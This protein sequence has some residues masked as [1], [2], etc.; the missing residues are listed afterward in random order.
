MKKL[1]TLPV[2]GVVVAMLGASVF[3]AS[4]TPGAIKAVDASGKD[5]G[6]KIVI[7]R[8]TS[9]QG[10]KGK[11]LAD[12]GLEAG[13]K[14]FKDSE[15]TVVEELDIS[16]NTAAGWTLADIEFPIA[17]TIDPGTSGDAIVGAHYTG[18]WGELVS[19]SS[20]EI[21]LKAESTLSPFLIAKA[22]AS[23]SAQTGEYAGAYIVMV[24]VAL[25]AAG[26]VFAVRAKKATR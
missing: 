25:V 11:T 22:S 24:A 19:G 23:S 7:T 18:K 26:A 2:I 10:V 12:I 3:A 16:V 13:N 17:V 9:E 6:D 1:M 14:D 15:F 21:T 20:S 5:L 4:P 8:N